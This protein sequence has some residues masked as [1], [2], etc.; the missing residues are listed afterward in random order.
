MTTTT[1]NI[2]LM[3]G[4]LQTATTT[5]EIILTEGKLH[6]TTT[7]TEMFWQKFTHTQS[8][9]FSPPPSTTFMIK[10]PIQKRV[11]INKFSPVNYLMNCSWY[12]L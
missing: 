11:N 3:E 2:I 4:Q 6:T 7:S 8:E 5:D 9:W 12:A 1:R 10:R